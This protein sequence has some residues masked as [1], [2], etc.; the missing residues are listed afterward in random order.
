MTADPISSGPSAT[1]VLI[2]RHLHAQAIFDNLCKPFAPDEVQWRI[3]PTNEQF[4]QPDE[5]LRAEAL[6]YVDA[7]TVMDRFDAVV[8]C[9][10][11]QCNY[12]LGTSSMLICT[13]GLCIDG[14]WIWKADGAGIDP[15]DVEAEKSALSD[16]FKLL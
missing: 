11:W 8:G 1:P 14:I 3:G 9:E 6:A 4:K 16:A 2:S 7:R 15:K 12:A 10:N 5:P 13:I